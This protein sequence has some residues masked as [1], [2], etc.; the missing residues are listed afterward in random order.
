MIT[1]LARNWWALA[2]RGVLAI[3]F[4]VP[5]FVM[6]GLTL[7]VLAILF[8][9]YTFVDGVFTVI[10]AVRARGDVARWWALLLEGVAG[11]VLALLIVALP[12]AAVLLLVYMVAAW[13]LITGV[14]EIIA[15]IRLRQQ[16]EGEWRLLLSGA[17][18][19]IFAIL[20]AVLPAAG[21]LSVAWTIGAYAIL[22]GVV[23]IALAWRLKGHADR[24]GGL[25]PA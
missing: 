9:A 19:V 7:E 15:A 22:F 5:A 10:A 23:L 8:A 13:A 11:I 12:G 17:L 3:L 20:V 4:G 18:S 14:L 1:E 24:A 21:V 2:L 16:I 6:P 25:A